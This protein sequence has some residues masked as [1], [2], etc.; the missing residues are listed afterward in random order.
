MA[1]RK[2]SFFI[3]LLLT[4]LFSISQKYFQ[5]E[6]KYTIHVA[7]DDVKHTLSGSDTIVYVNNSTTC[8]NEIWMHIWPNA[9]KDNSTALANQL[10]Q[11]GKTF[12]YF[13]NDSLKG[14]IDSLD[15]KVDNK[16]VNWKYDSV[17]IDICRLNLSEPLVPGDSITITTPFHVKIPDSRI[18]RC[19]HEG[20]SYQISQWFPKP[21]VY[22]STGWNA[23]PYLDQGEFYSEFG[24]FDVYIS[25]PENYVVGATGDLVDG[26]KEMEWLEKIAWKTSQAA[27]FEKS[28][29]FP[30]S[31]VT[32][33]TLHYHQEK[34]HDFAWFAD[35]R[36]N[37]LKGEV[38]LPFSKR[39]VTTWV[40]FTNHEA[41]L[42]KNAITYVNDAILYYSKW[43][44]EYPYNNA[45]AVQGA[46][47]AGGGMEYPNI[48]VI[49][50]G[51]S[52]LSL[53]MV[54]MHE[55]GHNWFY[56]ILGSNERK[57]P[58][59]D[60]GVN[61]FFEYRYLQTK[62]PGSTLF[63]QN[64]DK[65]LHTPQNLPLAE[66]AILY[67]VLAHLNADQPIGLPSEEYT[68]TSYG[69]IVYEKT[70]VVFQYLFNYLGE[71]RFDNA[72]QQY[73]SEWKY[74]HPYPSDL[75]KVFETSTG[76]DLDW[77]FTDM[78]NSDKKLDYKIC[79][80][81][82]DVIKIKNKGKINAPFSLLINDKETWMPGFN[83][84]ETDTVTALL[85]SPKATA[86]I[87]FNTDALEYN[88]KNNSSR[89]YGLFRK[90]KPLKIQ[91][92]PGLDDPDYMQCC[93]TP[94][95]GYNV[96]N[97][98]MPGLAFYNNPIPQKKFSYFL[99]PMYGTKNN[100]F[101]GI[102]KIGY[103]ILPENSFIQYI[104]TGL[105]ASKFTYF[106]DS[107]SLNYTKIAPEICIRLKNLDINS[108]IQKE[109]RI[110]NVNILKDDFDYSEGAPKVKNIQYYVNEISYSLS[111]KRKINPYNLL[112]K[113]EQGNKFV[114][115]SFEGNYRITYNKVRKGLDIRFFTGAFLYSD[116]PNDN[117]FRFRIS[118]E[119]SRHDYLFDRYYFDRS[120]VNSF[121][122]QQFS[123]TDGGFKVYTPL[124]QTWK[125]MAALNLKTSIPG[126]VPLRLYADFGTYEGAGATSLT[127]AVAYDAGIELSIINNIFEIYF[128][129]LVSSDI[130]KAN[131]LNNVT[132]WENI[133]FKLC[134]EKADPFKM[135]RNIK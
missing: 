13:S 7:L 134:L 18:S 119:Q 125:W 124:G 120:G 45:T 6:V 19:G 20:Q 32:T 23:F 93:I 25:L 28:T 12:F 87:N 80:F 39:K 44:G 17:N 83:G 59:I 5:Q 129:V 22:D 135:L 108:G 69:G 99:L 24:T 90:S 107:L 115:S 97:G 71:E 109:I 49:S 55:V 63:L 64:I 81:K 53:E 72:M 41:D 79:S 8:L 47:S 123:E 88:L 95:C 56:G 51:G 36:Y 105:S 76:E 98:C 112:L 61:S 82:K 122:S 29:A 126:K 86:Q 37:V 111:N 14:Y 46:L 26:D 10:L 131:D 96:N 54:V 73:F 68:E 34:V 62:Y 60:E 117:D 66:R 30:A 11:S 16:S 57:Y 38:E 77:F 132:Y 130:K 75:Q 35:K 91:L 116:S 52:A 4:P 3:F 104:Y 118:G 40:M 78:I 2:Y 33:K 1:S 106:Y 67:Q 84:T 58:W 48:T 127:N 21:A 100:T 113:V 74:K 9:Y 121:F 110:R 15:F 85:Q 43:I 94:V 92:L 114:K 42:W 89:N 27:N 70:A 102:A 50:S 101:N 65:V 103:M 31:S 133:R 128:P